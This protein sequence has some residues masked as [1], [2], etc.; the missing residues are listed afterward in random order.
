MKNKKKFDPATRPK[1]QPY[2]CKARTEG[3]ECGKLAEWQSAR[4]VTCY[5]HRGPGAIRLRIPA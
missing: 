2:Y 3:R 1:P 4:G 5:D